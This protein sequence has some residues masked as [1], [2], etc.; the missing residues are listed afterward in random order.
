MF[1]QICKEFDDEHDHYERIVELSRDVTIE[2]RRMSLFLHT[3]DQHEDN[4]EKGL[5]EAEHRLIQTCHIFFK[6]IAK[7]LQGQ[8]DSKNL[9]KR[10][11]SS[12]TS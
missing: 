8:T 12:T 3:A 9:L 1:S 10:G 11:S 7:E 4:K 2:A 6:R 5:S